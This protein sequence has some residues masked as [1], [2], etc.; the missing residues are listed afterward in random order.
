MSKTSYLRENIGEE[1]I[2]ESYS[3]R[4]AMKTRGESVARRK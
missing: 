2:E 1:N 4:K 3:I